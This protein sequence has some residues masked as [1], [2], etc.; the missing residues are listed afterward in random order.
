MCRF[1]AELVQ[2]INVLMILVLIHRNGAAW[3]QVNFLYKIQSMTRE[4]VGRLGI[5]Q[6]LQTEL[7]GATVQSIG[8]SHSH[9]HSHRRTLKHTHAYMPSCGKVGGLILI[10]IRQLSCGSWQNLLS[11]GVRAVEL[12]GPTRLQLNGRNV[13]W[14]GA[15]KAGLVRLMDS[16]GSKP[17]KAGKKNTHI[18]IR[19]VNNWS[20]I[21]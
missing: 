13:C 7:Q 4:P 12:M 18:Y 1:H 14:P 6:S 19:D 16:F 21:D 9:S 5:D 2:L 20:M 11:V 3:T 10:N 17:T 15:W 8:H